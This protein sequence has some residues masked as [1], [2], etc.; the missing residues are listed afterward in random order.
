MTNLARHN[1][2]CISLAVMHQLYL[3][4][5]APILLTRVL[6]AWQRFLSTSR[7]RITAA[8]RS[9]V[10]ITCVAQTSKENQERHLQMFLE[11]KISHLNQWLF[12]VEGRPPQGRVEG[13]LLTVSGDAQRSEEYYISHYISCKMKITYSW[14]MWDLVKAVKARMYSLP[15]ASELQPNKRLQ[16]DRFVMH[17][18]HLRLH[19][20]AELGY[21]PQLLS[22][23]GS[24]RS[25]RPPG[26]EQNK[27]SKLRGRG[28]SFVW[29]EAP[30]LRLWQL[31][32]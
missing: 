30:S 24:K 2:S 5:G 4:S 31:L 23:M 10:S 25:N 19:Q 28:W 14:D 1:A 18:C 15:T 12:R 11:P 29:G 13:G 16:T 9:I 3:P 17:L 27:A 6:L 26:F 22:D 7:S 8:H 21:L 20:I 32:L